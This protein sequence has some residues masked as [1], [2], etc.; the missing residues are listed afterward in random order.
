[1]PTIPPQFKGWSDAGVEGQAE[2][3]GLS[4]KQKLLRTMSPHRH[5][6]FKRALR[7]AAAA[8]DRSARKFRGPHARIAVFANERIGTTIKFP[9]PTDFDASVAR[10]EAI[11]RRV[12][13]WTTSTQMLSEEG[14]IYLSA[15]DQ[16]GDSITREMWDI[17]EQRTADLWA[18]VS[19]DLMIGN[20]LTPDPTQPEIAIALVSLRA[21]DELHHCAFPLCLVPVAETQQ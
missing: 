17:V 2:W 11:M 7:Q 9:A 10:G 8:I 19:S 15:I 1:M 3:L 4:T 21:K 12:P 6:M 18:A 20:L 14:Y 5:Q 13:P 16:H